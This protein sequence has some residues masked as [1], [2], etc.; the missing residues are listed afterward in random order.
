ME[1]MSSLCVHC[2]SEFITVRPQRQLLGLRPCPA[3]VGQLCGTEH[4]LEVDRSGDPGDCFKKYTSLG[5]GQLS[6]PGSQERVDTF[7]PAQHLQ[8]DGLCI[9]KTAHVAQPNSLRTVFR[10][11]QQ[12]RIHSS[13]KDS[14]AAVAK[15]Q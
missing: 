15:Q 3:C 13:Y 9:S 4:I 1:G 14:Q 12:Q 7:V 8:S 6:Q 11:Q 10:I 2:P 5:K